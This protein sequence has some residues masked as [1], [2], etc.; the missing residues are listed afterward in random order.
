MKEAKDEILKENG[1]SGANDNTEADSKPSVLDRF[2]PK[3][4]RKKVQEEITSKTKDVA[5]EK[6]IKKLC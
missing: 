4:E 2:K 3:K 6:E 5:R 1:I